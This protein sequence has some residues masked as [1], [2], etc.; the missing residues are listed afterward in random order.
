MEQIQVNDLVALLVDLP[1]QHIRRGEVG[2]VLEVFAAT[3]YHPAGYLVEFLD[4]ATGEWKEVDVTE[5]SQ[6]IKLHLKQKAA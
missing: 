4:E 1:S 3:A 2:T 6:L 5:D